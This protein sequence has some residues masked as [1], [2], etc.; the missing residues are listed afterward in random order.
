M[1]ADNNKADGNDLIV[2]FPSSIA[3]RRVG[4]ADITDGLY[5]R[6]P[7]ATEIQRRWYSKEDEARARSQVLRDAVQYSTV[8]AAAREN[9]HQGTHVMKACLMRCV[10]LESLISYNVPQQYNAIRLA[11][12]RHARIVLEDQR[13]Q[14]L[15]GAVSSDTLARVSLASSYQARKRAHR[16]AKTNESVS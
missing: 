15:L 1:N 6:Y 16:I 10:G 9:G 2:D 14:Q 7:S 13:K 11:R 4:I 3:E 8:L 12:K 5:I